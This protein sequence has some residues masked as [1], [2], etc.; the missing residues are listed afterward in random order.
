MLRLR[1]QDRQVAWPV[2]A[3]VGGKLD[4]DER[5]FLFRRSEVE[6]WLGQSIETIA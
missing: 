3:G 5:G 6:H 4:H 1:L 2:S